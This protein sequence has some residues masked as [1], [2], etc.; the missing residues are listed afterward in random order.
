MTHLQLTAIATPLKWPYKWW[1][2]VHISSILISYCFDCERVTERWQRSLYWRLW[3]PSCS[4][5][6]LS[7]SRTALWW[8]VRWLLLFT[9]ATELAILQDCIFFC[10]MPGWGDGCRGLYYSSLCCLQQRMYLCKLRKLIRYLRTMYT[11][12]W[13]WFVVKQFFNCLKHL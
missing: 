6:A 9:L 3:R 8:K 4:W 13:P 10:G 2:E 11:I 12:T 5:R 7:P 1:C